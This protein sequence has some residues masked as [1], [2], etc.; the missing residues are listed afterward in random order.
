MVPTP[1]ATPMSNLHSRNASFTIDEGSNASPFSNNDFITVTRPTGPLDKETAIE[2]S[3]IKND[4]RRSLN[5]TSSSKKRKADHHI[6]G[7][8]RRRTRRRR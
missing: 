1:P 8:Y 4:T 7:G 6:E 2:V 5:S 3:V